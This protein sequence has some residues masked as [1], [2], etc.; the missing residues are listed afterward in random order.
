M[1]IEALL[2]QLQSSPESVEF[3]EVIATINEHYYYTPTPF[4]NGIGEHKIV[5]EAGQNEGSCRIFAF[6]RLQGLSKEHTL[7]CF[8][9]NYR[10]EVLPFPLGRN[11]ANIRAF[12]LYGWMGIHFD[13]KALSPK[14][15]L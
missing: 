15:P 12:M 2:S 10:D 14:I 9:K 13:G 7:A 1:K 3:S 8:G 5:N 4:T 6:A 11:H